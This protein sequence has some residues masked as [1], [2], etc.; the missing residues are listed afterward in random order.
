MSLTTANRRRSL[1]LSLGLTALITNSLFAQ[2]YSGGIA[3]FRQLG[4]PDVKDAKYVKVT[5][6]YGNDH[7]YGMDRRGPKLAGNGWLLSTNT[8]GISV[9]LM[10][11]LTK[12]RRIDRKVQEKR[13]QKRMEEMEAKAKEGGDEVGMVLD[14]PLDMMQTG[15]FKEVDLKKDLDALLAHLKKKPGATK[16]SRFSS[17]GQNWGNQFLFAAHAHQKGFTKEANEVIALVMQKGGGSRKVL[18]S[19]MNQLADALYQERY[20]T[21]E[22][23]GD[24][25]AYAKGMR[26]LVARFPGV[27]RNSALVRRVIGEVDAHLKYTEPPPVSGADLT[28]EDR[29]LA[30]ELAKADKPLQHHLGMSGNW[31]AFNNQYGMNS[32][33]SVL[34]KIRERGVKSVPLL[35]ALLDDKYLVRTKRG[36]SHSSYSSH[37]MEDFFMD[38]E[39]IDQMYQHFTRPV[40]RGEIA[41]GLLTPLVVSREERYRSDMQP[42]EEELKKRVAKWYA[43]NKDKTRN[44]MIRGFLNSEEQ[45]ERQQA[46]NQ[47][48]RSKE[49]SDRQVIEKFILDT[50]DMGR[51]LRYATQF[52]QQHGD[53]VGE[54]AKTFIA[55][56]KQAESLVSADQLKYADEERKKRL[57]E[58]A[59]NQLKSLE[60]MISSKSAQELLDEFLASKEKWTTQKWSASSRVFWTKLK[61]MKENEI[62]TML[63]KG[64][65]AAKDDVLANSLLQ[66]AA[67]IQYLHMRNGRF[68]PS[69]P[70]KPF[71]PKLE[72]HLD[73][74]KQLITQKRKVAAQNMSFM[75]ASDFTFRQQVAGM[76][77]SL[78]GGGQNQARQWRLMQ[79]LGPRIMEIMA[80]RA[81]GRLAGKSEDE[82]PEYPD[83]DKVK[84]ERRAVIRQELAR[85]EPAK[86]GDYLK[87]L[88]LSEMLHVP[89][90][91]NEDPKL[92]QR[93]APIG[94]RISGVSVDIG[95]EKL[96][97]SLTAMDGKTFDRKAVEQLIDTGK[98]LI[99][100]GQGG[101]V[102]ITRMN[103]LAGV[104]VSV[105]EP[106]EQSG[107]MSGM[108]NRGTISAS[109]NGKGPEGQIWAHATWSVEMP[110]PKKA[111]KK[112]DPKK[113]EAAEKIKAA[114]ASG[115]TAAL[116]ALLESGD[117][118]LLASALGDDAQIEVTGVD[119]EYLVQ[120]QDEFFKKLDQLLDPKANISEPFHCTLM[121]TVPKP[122]Q[123]G[124]DF[125]S[126]IISEE[127]IF[128]SIP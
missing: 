115:D 8:N 90:F 50:G 93:F 117:P 113:N 46:F 41:R 103:P 3:R 97:K 51:A 59:K 9:V 88:S 107:S 125:G 19:A 65:I 52:V 14:D 31:I 77:E 55:K 35:L 60:E 76:V 89:D 118:Q 94:N 67:Q 18:G 17:G 106:M 56:A 112:P 40:T 48:L 84:D 123:P 73:L 99:K 85:I 42:D 15:K 26:E 43:A 69:N 122:G 128:N 111:E 39:M 7:S 21:F 104:S 74:W 22:E 10:N 98:S 82:L 53:S 44:E 29:Q 110:Q 91:L 24:W 61:S 70:P 11:H 119:N 78:Y 28:D 30:A 126:G 2:D 27:W 66:G 116:Q 96:K 45:S 87:G 63:L 23:D 5:D 54:F 108:G 6:A 102:M 34:G 13:Q 114:I 86:A 1:L 47:L 95:D 57:A 20:R 127:V 81:E 72:D 36:E 32:K 101:I 83:K 64:A 49:E 58:Q 124:A 71:Q 4:L 100:S 121:L 38:E 92:N 12:Q 33:T 105:N 109:L 79:T 37:D 68:D 16:R 75:K 120:Q 62:L 80:L 25:K